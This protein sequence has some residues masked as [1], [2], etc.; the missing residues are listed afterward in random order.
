MS[1]DS[2]ALNLLTEHAECLIDP[3]AKRTYNLWVV[4]PKEKT[5]FSPKLIKV[6]ANELKRNKAIREL[7]D[8]SIISIKI[9]KTLTMHSLLQE[10][11]RNSIDDPTYLYAVTEVFKYHCKNIALIYPDYHM[12]L[13]PGEAK[14]IIPAIETL[15][16][17]ANE[18][19][20]GISQM[21]EAMYSNRTDM[22]ELRFC[23]YSFKAR[24]LTDEGISKNNEQL[25]IEADEHYVE[26]CKIAYWYYGG[27]KMI[28][29]SCEIIVIQERYNRMRVNLILGRYDIAFQIYE[30][31]R[32]P[33]EYSMDIRGYERKVQEAFVNFGDLWDEFGYFELAKE[34]YEFALKTM[35]ESTFTNDERKTIQVKIAEC[36]CVSD[37]IEKL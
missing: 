25:L 1:A 2:L 3:N 30:D 23:Y 28:S 31:A 26:S 20:M 21:N 35:V 6:L 12:S 14:S 18:Y 16:L 11:V 37:S 7:N 9:D 22:I 8:Y 19:N 36:D 27:N 34:C 33:L 17:Y 5:L 4:P 32:I 29:C 15:L 24:F 13:L 10:V